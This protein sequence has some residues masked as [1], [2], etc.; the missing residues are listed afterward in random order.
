MNSTVF[1]MPKRR[2]KRK[3][4]QSR[5]QGPL[6]PCWEILEDSRKGKLWFGGCLSVYPLSSHSGFQSTP[7]KVL[8]SSKPAPFTLPPPDT[9]SLATQSVVHG[10][11]AWPSSENMLEMQTLKHH[12]RLL[13]SE[14]DFNRIPRCSLCKL[15]FEKP[16]ARKP[17]FP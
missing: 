16:W 14:S 1:H 13:E 2:W 3:S 15:Q 7:R 6:G 5:S 4:M 8:H 9:K 10:P 11:A 17:W 12:S